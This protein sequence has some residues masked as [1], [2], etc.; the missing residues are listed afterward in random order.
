[1]ELFRYSTCPDKIF[2][3][4][5]FAASLGFGAGMPAMC[6]LFGALSDNMGGAENP[7][8]FSAL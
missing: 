6:L 3:G 5:G 1:M 4:F 2:A 8:G 7:E